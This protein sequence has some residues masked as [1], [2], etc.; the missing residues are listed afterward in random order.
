MVTIREADENDNE[1]LIE[2]TSKCP[3]GTNLVIGH[4]SSPDFFVRSKAFEDWHVF[5]AHEHRKIAGSA[6]CSINNIQFRGEPLKAAYLYG[7]MVDPEY[8]RRGIAA[9]LHKHI[10]DFAEQNA[11]DLLYLTVVEDNSPAIRFFSKMG[12][13]RVN[14]FAFLSLMVYKTHMLSGKAKIR[15]MRQNDLREV[16]AMINNTYEDYELFRPFSMESFEEYIER[17]PYFDMSDILVHES[18][19]NIR[20]CVGYWDHSKVRRVIV[21]GYNW[22]FKMLTS[23][24]RFIGLFTTVPRM[25]KPGEIYYSYYLVTP[26]YKDEESFSSLIK[27]V[28]NV[29]LRNGMHM[30]NTPVDPESPLSRI[31]SRFRHGKIKMHLFVKSLNHQAAFHLSERK[32]YVDSVEM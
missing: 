17:I 11:V 3:M 32:L 1:V 25:P 16:V 10:E 22:R 26:A 29:G 19:G 30:I 2:L 28:M 21:Q 27:Y 7:F 20:A 15:P 31:L 12:L 4:D 23:F 5:V 14:D 6:A 18:D 24:M 13:T 8:R 9:Q